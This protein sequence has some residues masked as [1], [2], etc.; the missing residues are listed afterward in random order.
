MC[1]RARHRHQSSSFLHSPTWTPVHVHFP[2]RVVTPSPKMAATAPAI[3]NRSK[4]GSD[5][6]TKVF[7]LHVLVS[8][9]EGNISQ[10]PLADLS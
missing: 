3:H 2:C 1:S 10:K 5:Q 8:Y 7:S 4:A 9:H 6:G